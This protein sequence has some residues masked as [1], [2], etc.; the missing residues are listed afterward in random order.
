M[1][2]GWTRPTAPLHVAPL[3]YQELS[4]RTIPTVWQIGVNTP[5]PQFGIMVFV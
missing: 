3:R 1:P 2:V 4:T 5:G